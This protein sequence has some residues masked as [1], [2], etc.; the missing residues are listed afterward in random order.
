MR[1]RDVAIRAWRRLAGGQ[2]AQPPAARYAVLQQVF[3]QQV[4]SKCNLL[5][6]GTF[7][8]KTAV[9]LI[10]TALRHE[11]RDAV[12]YY[13]FDLWEDMDEPTFQRELSKRRQ[14]TMAET[15]SRIAL[16]TGLPKAQIHLTRGD[17][18]KT[19]WAQ[20]P[21]LPIMD[22]MFIDGGHSTATVASDWRACETLM[23][24]GGMVVFD[25]YFHFPF[26][27]RLVVDALDP[28]VYAVT[29]LAPQDV[30]EDRFGISPDGVLRINLAQVVRRGG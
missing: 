15:Q 14:T 16:A 5:E 22:F 28:A 17:S 19:L 30:F 8:G 1:V 21:A 23:G 12:H 27:P 29:V 10:R 13:G 3:E 24:S 6:I 2:K 4:P 9:A 11:S 7:K 26:G 18:T 20:L 25:D